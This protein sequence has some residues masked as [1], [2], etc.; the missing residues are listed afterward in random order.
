M[1][2]E[3]DRYD[4]IIA[5]GVSASV[6]GRRWLWALWTVAGGLVVVG[7]FGIYD[8]DHVSR[9]PPDLSATVL[10]PEQV[11]ALMDMGQGDVAVAATRSAFAD[12]VD[13]VADDRRLIVTDG[14]PRV[15]ANLWQ[16]RGRRLDVHLV[17]YSTDGGNLVPTAPIEIAVLVP[18]GMAVSA[19]SIVGPDL[20]RQAVDI[21]REGNRVHVRVPSFDAYAI[22][23]L[24]DAA[25]MTAARELARAAKALD[26][27]EVA[28]EEAAAAGLVEQLAAADGR[29]E[30]RAYRAA[31][32]SARQVAVGPTPRWQIDQ[33]TNRAETDERL[34]A[35]SVAG[36]PGA[37]LRRAT[38]DGW[39][40]S[41]A[42]PHDADR[43]SLAHQ[44][45]LGN[46]GAGEPDTPR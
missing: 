37:G 46:A 44:D 13:P 39:Y 25:E 11:E 30:A 32:A 9:T 1:P 34:R 4:T 23:S 14:G 33:R 2:A 35:S 38:T 42:R 40:R 3:L 41:P 24:G 18:E 16:H 10:A 8:E 21:R 26:R 15:W 31:E 17:N 45:A 12:L 20:P 19:A 43:A 28:G 7:E 29:Y 5:A 22:V 36:S 6:R 27:L